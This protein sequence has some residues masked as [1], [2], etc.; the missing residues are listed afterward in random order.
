MLG[1]VEWPSHYKMG[2]RQYEMILSLYEG[3]RHSL[4]ADAQNGEW[5]AI[6]NDF[7]TI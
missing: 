6:W 1:T 7:S 3:M 2:A 5:E 4:T